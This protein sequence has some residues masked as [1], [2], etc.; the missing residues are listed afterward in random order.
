MRWG[1]SAT[2]GELPRGLEV[3]EVAVG[4]EIPED[5]HG[6]NALSAGFW[7]VAAREQAEQDERVSLLLEHCERSRAAACV[8]S[9]PPSLHSREGAPA[10]L[11]RLVARFKR[12]GSCPVYFDFGRAGP[13]RWAD[14]ALAVT[15]PLWPL[16]QPSACGSGPELFGRY[17]KIHGW[18][19]D[20]W[21]RRYASEQLGR[22]IELARAHQPEFVILAH[23]S[24]VEQ[25]REL[26]SLLRLR[27]KP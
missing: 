27:P 12:D 19:P 23:S 7:F 18:H 9:V 26:A 22:L 17:W 24:R 10:T 8:I 11:A 4:A 14:P 21:V 16:E 3:L 20:R 2:D 15:D 1:I 5:A 6:L 13:P 25:W